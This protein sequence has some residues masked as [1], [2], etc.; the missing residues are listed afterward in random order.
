MGT[1]L[2][3]ESARYVGSGSESADA[4]Q[5]E[6][7]REKERSTPMNPALTRFNTIKAG[8]KINLITI[9]T[10]STAIAMISLFGTILIGFPHSVYP[11]LIAC[12][13]GA[14]ALI[15]DFFLICKD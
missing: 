6:L 4:G 9:A 1:K 10:V 7:S 15:A 12:L 11:T 5:N 14:A 3:T 13:I 8:I 2:Q